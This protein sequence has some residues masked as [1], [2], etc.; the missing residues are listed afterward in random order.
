VSGAA[1]TYT[2]PRVAPP[3]DLTVTITVTPVDLP[4]AQRVETITIPAIALS[5]VPVSALLPLNVSQRFAA[6]VSNDDTGKGVTW[7]LSQNGAPCSPACGTDTPLATASG[8]STTYTAPATLPASPALHLTATSV[9][10]TTKSAIAAVTLTNG[11]VS[12][13][14]ADLTLSAGS[15][16]LTAILTNTSSLPLTISGMVLAGTNPGAFSESNDCGAVVAAGASCK[17]TV[18]YK[19]P[20]IVCG[21]T[22]TAVLNITDNSLDSPQQLHLTGSGKTST[23]AALHE[24]LRSHAMA[25]APRP[26]GASQVGTRLMHLTDAVHDD[27]YLADG[28]KRELMVRFWYPTPGN[29]PCTPAAYTSAAVLSEFSQLLGATTLPQISTNSCLDAPVAAGAHPI[30][31]ITHGFTGTFTDYTFLTEDLASR[32]YVVASVDH[33]HE[34]TA[35]EFPNGTVAKSVFGSHLTSYT[36]SD[37]QALA[38]AVSVRV[39]DLSFVL[40]E[41]AALAK[42]R[43][44]VFAG[45]L[46]LSRIALAGHSLGGL[47]AVRGVEHDARFR[48]AISLDG[49]VPDRLTLLTSTPVLLLTA[50]RSQWNENDCQL[51]SALQGVRLAVNL[52]G[53]EHIAF[54][55]ALWLGKGAVATG[56]MG[57]D[58]TVTAIR[59]V[60]AAFLDA[61]FT[62]GPMNA[63]AIP[64]LL[65]DLDTVVTTQTQSRCGP[66]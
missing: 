32:G 12:L 2:A 43:D 6:T 63:P 53:A 47:T 10:D 30:V 54:S 25:A 58:K 9:T 26:T 23:T 40:D 19:C 20:G 45:K 65:T 62:G 8:P 28:T 5:V 7:A 15:K 17:I 24:A 22:Q 21:K 4:G 66:G 61:V 42:A 52:N 64:S 46:D 56:R 16:Q 29:A 36:R 50:G 31:V 51:W 55:D 39:G 48:A 1:V 35:V 34:A 33:T 11:G 13:V 60:S 27:P 44:G 41:L 57:M 49:L 3:G 37:P 14:P 18:T 59:D 38:F